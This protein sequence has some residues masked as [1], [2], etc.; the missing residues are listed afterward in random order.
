MTYLN[1]VR[2]KNNVDLFPDYFMRNNKKSIIIAALLL[3]LIALVYLIGS[4]IY[5]ILNYKNENVIQNNVILPAITYNLSKKINLTQESDELIALTTLAQE[6]LANALTPFMVDEQRHVFITNNEGQIVASAPMNSILQNKNINDFAPIHDAYLALGD[7]AGLQNIALGAFDNVDI[8]AHPLKNGLGL[9][10]AF[11]PTKVNVSK[12]SS[13]SSFNSIKD[14]LLICIPLF[15]LLFLSFYS[16]NRSYGNKRESEKTK[17]DSK[18]H[19]LASSF[20]SQATNWTWHVDKKRLHKFNFQ[21]N[22]FEAT[23]LDENQVNEKFGADFAGFLGR[24]YVKLEENVKHGSSHTNAQDIFTTAKGSKIFIIATY[25]QQ[26]MSGEAM[27]LSMLE[28]GIEEHGEKT[29]YAPTEQHMYKQFDIGFACIHVAS[30]GVVDYLNPRFKA[31]F[32][33]QSSDDLLNKNFEDILSLMAPPKWEELDRIEL[34]QG[35]TSIYHIKIAPNSIYQVKE[36]VDDD[37]AFTMTIADITTV[38]QSLGLGGKRKQDVPLQ[39]NSK[40]TILKLNH[41]LRTPLNHIHGFAQALQQD[42]TS[43]AAPGYVQHIIEGSENLKQVIDSI[44][45]HGEIHGDE[46][47]ITKQPTDMGDLISDLSKK[48]AP[49][50]LLSNQKLYTDILCHD[51]I[52]D[53]DKAIIAKLFDNILENAVEH[54]DNADK[55]IVRLRRSGMRCIIS[56]IDTGIGIDQDHIDRAYQSFDQLVDNEEIN[57][58]SGLGLGLSTAKRITE[59]HGGRFRIRSKSGMGTMISVSL[60]L[61]DIEDRINSITDIPNILGSDPDPENDMTV[62]QLSEV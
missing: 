31:F 49:K 50:A 34:D 47:E 12:W 55:I 4:I 38:T 59:L 9:I 20:L 8:I 60:P 56:V 39:M 16:L 44:M 36:K 14:I 32:N 22:R 26:E 25:S 51:C 23:A 28:Y 35:R 3:S 37:G 19:L 27:Q 40:E 18:N 46:A 54:A 42:L 11:A 30:T 10:Y 21:E 5:N 43:S 17:Q 7:D 48:W 41:N 24:L 61:N 2:S 52:C 33:I 53:I 6:Q 15:S 13:L 29:E 45:L 62:K 57:N 1:N 58:K